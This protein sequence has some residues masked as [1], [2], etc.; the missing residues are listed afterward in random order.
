MPKQVSD[1]VAP[2]FIAAE[3]EG[4]YIGM[5]FGRLA[6]GASEPEWCSISH[7]ECDGFGA[8][9]EIFRKRGVTFDSLPQAKHP[10]KPSMFSFFRLLQMYIAA[11]AA[12]EMEEIRTGR[13]AELLSGATTGDGVAR[14]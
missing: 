14:V 10:A 7:A 13:E 5:R 1:P 8:I 2:W 3:A 11:A 6:P 9:G 4:E 12:F